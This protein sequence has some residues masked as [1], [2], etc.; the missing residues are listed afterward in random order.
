MEGYKEIGTCMLGVMLDGGSLHMTSSMWS[1]LK[2]D[3]SPPMCLYLYLG[4]PFQSLALAW[5]GVM[6][7]GSQQNLEC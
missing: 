3:H 4:V 1:L 2:Q 5:P 7:D 6:L